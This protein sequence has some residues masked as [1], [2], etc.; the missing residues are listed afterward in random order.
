MNIYLTKKHLKKYF[1]KTY[2]SFKEIIFINRRPKFYHIPTLYLKSS[3]KINEIA[4]LNKDEKVNYINE[5]IYKKFDHKNY[6]LFDISELLCPNN[7][8]IVYDEKKLLYLDEDHW[9]FSGAKYFGKKL[10]DNNFLK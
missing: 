4:N 7:R 6:Q 3:A 2:T 8:C 9:S 1:V 5:L 10:F